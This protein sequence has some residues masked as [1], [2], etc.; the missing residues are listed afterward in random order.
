MKKSKR[1][2]TQQL[3]IDS[4]VPILHKFCVE[5]LFWLEDGVNWG[6][7]IHSPLCGL[8]NVI[9]CSGWVMTPTRHSFV[10]AHPLHPIDT[11]TTLYAIQLA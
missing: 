10:V 6:Y 7:F 11:F 4:G 8:F 5:G 9:L 1:G 3:R 2:Q